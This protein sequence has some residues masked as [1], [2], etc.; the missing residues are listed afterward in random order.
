MTGAKRSFVITCC[1]DLS[2]AF[3]R[4]LTIPQ[5][6]IQMLGARSASRF[7]STM[8]AS[9]NETSEALIK[10]RLVCGDCYEEIKERNVLGTEANNPIQ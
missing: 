9:G 6:P 4:P 3:S 2:K 8:G 7:G 1:M 5:I 10:V